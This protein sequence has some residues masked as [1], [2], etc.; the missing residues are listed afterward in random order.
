LWPRGTLRPPLGIER[1]FAL[2]LA[3]WIGVA[4]IVFDTMGTV[5]ARYLEALS[6][7]LAAAIGYG[8]AT[9]AGLR[10]TR[11]PSV[12]ASALAL[13]GIGAYTLHFK[14]T[15]LGWGAGALVIAAVGAALVTKGSG[16]LGQG[17]R[18]LTAG[19]IVSCALIFPVHESL[20][21]VRSN[22]NDSLGLATAPAGNAV[23]LSRY[24]GNRTNGVR[25]ELAADEPLALAPLIIHDQRPLLPLT[26][27]GGLPLTSVSELQSAVRNGSVRYGLVDAHRCPS[28]TGRVAACAPAALWIRAHG[29]D[30]TPSVGLVGRA[31]LYLLSRAS[32]G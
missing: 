14:P 15:S 8:A 17:A 22:A 23:A 18:W 31:R 2:C 11:G 25:Y 16:R 10:G 13:A 6:P 19:L 7:A 30:V 27:F 28:L 24:L 1:A 4:V 21:L 3:V 20:S 5:H 9:L 12:I 32:A 29:V 26:S